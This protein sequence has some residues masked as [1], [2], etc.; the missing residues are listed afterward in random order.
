[1]WVVFKLVPKLCVYVKKMSNAL[2]LCRY[3]SDVLSSN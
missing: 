1:M 3:V 2:L